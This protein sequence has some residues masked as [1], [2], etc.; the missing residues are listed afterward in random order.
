MGSAPA[1][2][3]TGHH[4][5]PGSPHGTET[6]ASHNS[7]LSLLSRTLPKSTARQHAFAVSTCICGVN[8]HM[9]YAG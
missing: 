5:L 9:V 6:A 1:L 7:Y 3:C 2:G 4:Q 8:M